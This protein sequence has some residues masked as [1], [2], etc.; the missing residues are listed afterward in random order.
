MIALALGAGGGEQGYAPHYAKGLMARVAQRRGMEPSA[1]MVSSAT[2]PLGAWLWVRGK[3]GATLLCQVVDVS[4]PR[5]I[6]RHI[7]TG[8]IVELSYE[9]T[10]ALCGSTRERSIDCPITIWSAE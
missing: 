6:K 9:V 4:H 7:R 10:R 5:D 8:R 1:C 3:T 2:H